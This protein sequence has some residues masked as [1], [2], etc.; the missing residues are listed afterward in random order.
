[1]EI[2]LF[3]IWEPLKKHISLQP[4][5][6]YELK[7]RVVGEKT[8]ET[9]LIPELMPDTVHK[10]TLIKKKQTEKPG[11]AEFLE[12][13]KLLKEGSGR[14][15]V[16]KL[17][18]ADKAG[19]PEAAYLLGELAEQGIGR[20]FSS[21]EDALVY[22]KKAALPPFNHP[23]AQLKL[24]A[25]Y[26]AGRGGLDRELKTALKWYRQ[27]A[28]QKNPDA[29]YRLGLAYKNGDGDEPVDYGKM[30]HFFTESA[31]LGHT[32]AQYQAG[33]GYEN[34]IGVPINVDK[35]RYWY[36]KAADSGHRSA[37]NRGKALENLK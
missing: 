29:L 30:M 7:W 10:I 4:F 33:Y 16:E 3:G 11:K 14:A 26:E 6:A 22:Y 36:Q 13:E 35:A 20:W 34:G 9:V 32:E 37:R 2:N 27:A 23:K 19:H 8:E 28:A 24:G 25:F 18:L 31:E 17:K 5:H 21:D 1:M 12:A 15:A